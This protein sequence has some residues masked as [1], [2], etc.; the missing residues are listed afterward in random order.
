M[1]SSNDLESGEVS[2][3]SWSLMQILT[4]F[5]DIFT[6]L[7]VKNWDKDLEIIVLRQQVRILQRKVNSPPVISDPERII[8]AILTDKLNQSTRDARRRRDQVMMVFKPDTVLGW[9][10]E[11]VRRKWAFKRK[12]KPGRPVISSELETLIVRLAKENLR[13]GYDKIRGEL[14][15][16]GYGISAS[17]VRNILK[18]H[19]IATSSERSSGSWRNFLG[20]Y[21]GQILACDFFTVET[22]WL[23]TIYVLF[24]IELGT[25]RVHLA[26]WTTNPNATWVTQQAR[27]LVWYLKDDPQDMAYLIHDNDTKFSSSFDTVFYSEGIKTVHTPFRAPRANAF[28]ERWVRSIREECLDH[29]LILNE[30]HLCR[31]LKE[32][33]EYSNHA[34][35]HQGIDQGFPVSGPIR[36]PRGPVRRRDVL[37]GVIHDYYRQPSALVS[38]IG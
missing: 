30:S 7:G 33:L 37:G 16:L 12:G 19:W 10:R 5:L 29:I 32:Y 9:H 26:G 4:F 22:I 28:A 34:R 2:M 24:F 25:R 23:K 20:H 15:K 17:S 38:G 31:V 1:V 11:L 8:L 27:Q 13:W 35:P 14:L 36:T 18:Q 3:V 21:K 6:I